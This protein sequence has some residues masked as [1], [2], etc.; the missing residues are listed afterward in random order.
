MYQTIQ[1]SRLFEQMAGQIRERILHNDIQIGE[2]L[3]NE[4]DLAKQFGVSRTVVREAMKT[5]EKEG[6]VQVQPGRGTFVVYGTEQ[7]IKES[8]NNLIRSEQYSDW[9]FLT[10]VRE[11]L[12]PAIAALAAER[13]KPEHIESLVKAV[14]TM[15]EFM[16]DA[17]AFIN[18]DNDFHLLLAKATGN[19]LLI[20]LV[21]PIVGLLTEQ[22]KR[23]FVIRGGPQRGQQ[24]HK[25]ILE[26]IQK[27]DP[28]AARQA[29]IAHLEQ[30][31]Q[32]SLA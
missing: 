5:L 23:I 1:P 9:S 11:I 2:R 19:T 12:E 17:E 13:A 32:D 30:I 16:E 22:R 27:H 24:H 14:N 25:A 26:A 18:A 20:C 4:H 8:L 15:D 29:C 3:P 31:N 10:E 28:K 7:A 6:F 21:E